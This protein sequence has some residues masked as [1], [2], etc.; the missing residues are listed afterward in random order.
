[1]VSDRDGVEKQSQNI[2][3]L[4][5]KQ[6]V[7]AGVNTSNVKKFDDDGVL[8]LFQLFREPNSRN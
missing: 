8:D 4:S 5:E 3:N 2:S 7:D 1:M 6:Y